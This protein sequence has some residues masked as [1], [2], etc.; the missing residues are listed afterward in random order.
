MLLAYG[1]Y[2]LTESRYDV[3]PEFAPAQVVIQTEAPGLSPGQVEVLVTQPIEN[4]VNGVVGVSSMRSKSLQGISVIT[5]TFKSGTDLYRDR[6][7]VAERLP[8]ITG[9]LPAGVKSPIIT[10]L[11]SS[12]S[13]IMAVGMTS[14]SLSLMNLR[15]IA[16]WTVKP[17]LLAVPGVAKVAVYGEGVKELQI[18][19]RPDLLLKYGLSVNDIIATARKATGVEGAGF[20][21]TH[22]QRIVIRTEGQSLAPSELGNTVL[23]QK[24]GAD[25]FL[26]DVANVVEAPAAPIGAAQ[27][28][29]K[30]GILMIISAQYGANTLQVT[31]RIEK[32]LEELSPALTAQHVLLHRNVFRAATFID[33]AV[34]NLSSSLLLGAILVVI[35]LLLFLFNLRTAAISLTVI[36]L[37]LLTAVVILQTLGYSLNTMTLGGLAIAIGEVVDDAVIDVENIL[38]RLRE[39]SHSANPEPKFRVVLNASIEVRSAIVYATF[40]VAF[41][42]V[43]VLTMT[44]LAGRL[45]SPLGLAY[46]FSIL[47]SLL[48]ALTVTP[49]LC[50]FLLGRSG[51]PDTEPLF[52]QWLKKTYR[53]ILS[54]IE[55]HFRLVIAGV[56]LLIAVGIVL[57]PTF[58]DSF[59]PKLREGSYIVHMTEIPGTSLAQ[60]LLLGRRVTARLLQIPFVKSVSQDAGRAELSDDTHGTHQSEFLV[61]LKPTKSINA[62]T[63]EETIRKSLDEFIGAKFSVNSVL[64]ERIHETLS[65]YTSAI[66]IDIFGNNLDT[67]DRTAQQVDRLVS[68]I[69]GAADVELQSPPGEPQIVI[70]IERERLDEWGFKPVDVMDAIN[71]AYQGD[72][73]GQVYD[74]NRVFNVVVILGSKERHDPAAVGSLLLQNP[75][76]VYVHLDQLARVYETSGR[77]VILHD[78]ARRVQTITCNVEGKSTEAFVAQIRKLIGSSI[79]LPKGTYVEFKGTAEAQARSKRDLLIHSLLAGI[80]IVILLS[81]VMGNLNNLSLVLANLPFALVGGVLSVFLTGGRLSLGSLVGFVTLFGITLRNSIMLISHYEHLVEKE[82]MTWS[83]DAALRGASERLVPILMTATVTGL[84][85]LPLALASGTAGREIEGPMAVVILGGLFTSTALN[86]LVLPTLSLKFGKFGERTGEEK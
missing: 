67:L 58:K 85:I 52:T 23:L 48:F 19:I 24:D 13:V 82:G 18:Q 78:G 53:S 64:M 29:G 43:P 10:P 60:T 62:S 46:I 22:N 44:G 36:P 35:V 61:E 77:Y 45:F 7:L 30:P 41:V 17:R 76:G 4:T 56:T 33:T 34:S 55:R 42:F 57:I 70:D 21:D 32:A 12:T 9:E 63:A 73:V 14:D 68:S 72:V 54:S 39:N 51:S 5:I 71:T 79:R 40:A 81:V 75:D 74:G 50:F 38:R 8:A 80:G 31:A 20:I 15:T 3:F 66:A 27:I 84:G 6:Q 47:A 11:T 2:T 59:L 83:L 65:G 1:L 16:D 69:R 28:M 37:S 86:L 26:K 49:A 25:V